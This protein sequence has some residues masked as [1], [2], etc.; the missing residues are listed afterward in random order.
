MVW[1]RESGQLEKENEDKDIIAS[2]RPRKRDLMLVVNMKDK[3]S[4]KE[5]VML[6]D[7]A[8]SIING[9]AGQI[10]INAVDLTWS[11]S[12]SY[13]VLTLIYRRRGQLS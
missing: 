1:L 11:T 7:A 13:T 5:G 8:P 6:Y 2:F 10:K 12:M 9:I 4:T 3:R